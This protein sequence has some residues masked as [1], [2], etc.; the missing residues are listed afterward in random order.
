VEATSSVPLFRS[1]DWYLIPVPD[2]EAGLAFYRDRLGHALV[3]RR[4]TAAGLRLRDTGAQIV[5]TTDLQFPET[6]FLVDS[7]E[8]AVRTFVDAGGSIIRPP[9]DIPTGRCAVVRDP[10]GNCHIILDQSK[11][12]Y[13]VEPDG[14]VRHD[15][16]GEPV[17]ESASSPGEV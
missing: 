7:T 15:A 6:D 1:F 5:L 12:S 14:S 16:A 8:T 3:W 17:V 10:W 9:F 2:L 11:G 13:I 4:P